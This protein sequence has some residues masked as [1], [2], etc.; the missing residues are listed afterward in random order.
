[1][2]DD[3]G[4]ML[5]EAVEAESGGEMVSTDTQAQ[6]SPTDGVTESTTPEPE[7]QQEQEPQFDTSALTEQINSQSQA[8]DAMAKN[9]SDLTNNIPKPQAPQP[10]E[11]DILRNQMKKDL[12]LDKMEEQFKAQEQRIEQQQQQIAIQEQ[13]EI[14]RNREYEFKTMEAQYGSID[15]VAVQNKILEVRKTN[16]ELANALISPDGV[17]MLLSQGVGVVDKNPDPITPSAS[18][19]EVDNS[20]Q[21]KSL[22]DG[23][24]SDA[25]FGALLEGAI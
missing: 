18:G 16:P 9:I 7:A 10:T 6:P 23:S 13:A 25:D 4:A 19:Q 12:G 17:R 2:E 14:S 24:L 3:L 20:A 1:M 15:K 11:E 5:G 21:L 8:M 22:A